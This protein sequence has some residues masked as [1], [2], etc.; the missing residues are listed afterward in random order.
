MQNME[1]CVFL[2]HS[3]AVREKISM[4]SQNRIAPSSLTTIS[5]FLKVGT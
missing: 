2:Y 3:Q 5:M 1:E 4:V